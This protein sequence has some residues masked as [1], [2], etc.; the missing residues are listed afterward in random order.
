MKAHLLRMTAALAVWGMIIVVPAA[1]HE[2]HDAGEKKLFTKH[3]NESLFDITKNA[4]YSIEILLDDKEYDIGKGVTGIILHNDKDADVTGATVT[5]MM[6]NLDS[7]EPA[8]GTPTVAEKGGGLYLVEGLDLLQKGRW[9]LT[10]TAS[11]DGHED[12]AVFIL[13]DVLKKRY[14]KGRYSP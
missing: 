1:A 14:K 13:P 7:G 4:S 3:F 6:K 11:K 9:E 12:R 10:V 5:V 8:S 2:G